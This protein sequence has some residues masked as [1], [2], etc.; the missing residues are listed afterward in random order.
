VRM[1]TSRHLEFE[2]PICDEQ[3][4]EVACRGKDASAPTEF[5]RR[6]QAPALP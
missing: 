6:N 1:Y 2:R 5:R 3:D 4:V